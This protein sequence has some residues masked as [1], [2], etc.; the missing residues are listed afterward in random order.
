MNP[1]SFLI[2]SLRY[3]GDVLLSTPLA[4]SIRAAFPEA[5]VDYLVFE[6]TETILTGNP[7]VREVL[8]VPPGSRAVGGLLRRWKRYDVSVGVNASDRTAFQ[9]IAAG[10]TS[11]GFADPRPK[12]WWKKRAFSHCSVYDPDK[13]V[14]ELLLGQL[15]YLGIP[16]VPEVSV[17]VRDNDRAGATRACGGEEFVLLH[18]YT[19]WEYKKW[20]SVHWARLSGRIEREMGIRTLFTVAPGSFERRIREEL[21][22]AGVDE[23]RFAPGPLTLGQAAALVAIAEAYVGIDTVITHMA[24]A[25]GRRTVAIFGPT[26]PWRWGPWPNGHPVSTPYDH[27]GGTQRKG[28]IAI[29]QKDWD[30]VA[31]DRMGCDH[32]PESASRCLVELSVEEVYSELFL[33]MNSREA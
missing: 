23:S 17:P 7:D 13:H 25:L 22:E 3:I 11:V 19:R 16:P 1:K 9:V 32:T 24:A 14:V 8:T 20:P 31:C 5:A 28:N 26:P 10:K 4:R 6:G 27:R 30:C 15:R 18:P 12:E 33:L 21:A 2:V 29:V